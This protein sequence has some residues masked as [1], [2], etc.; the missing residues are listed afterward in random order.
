MQQ[1]SSLSRLQLCRW[2]SRFA[3]MNVLVFCLVGVAFIVHWPVPP[4]D[5]IPSFNLIAKAG[6]ILFLVLAFLGNSTL[7]AFLAAV[8]AFC[9]ALLFRQR[10]L[11]VLI[12]ILGASLMVLLLL[13]DSVVFHL[14]HYHMMGIVWQIYRSGA[15][16]QVLQFSWLEW[17]IVAVAGL[18]VFIL[19]YFVSRFVWYRWQKHQKQSAGGMSI[20]YLMVCL[21]FSYMALLMAGGVT[22][23]LSP[24]QAASTVITLEARVIPFY[25]F[26]F[27]ELMPKKSMADSLQTTLSGGFVELQNLVKPLNYPLHPLHFKSIKKP[28][29]IVVIGIDTWR[30]DQLN[31]TV[32]PNI[33]AFAQRS[34][35]FFDHYSGGNSTQP[36]LFSLFYSLPPNYWSAML[37]EK[38]G[39]VFIHQLLKDKYQ[40]G[41]FMSASMQFPAFDDT[42]F[43]EV[44][45]LQ[46]NTPG[47]DPYQRDKRITQEFTHFIKNRDG[48]RPFFSFLFYDQVHGYCSSGE[49]FPKPFQPAVDQCDHLTL[50]NNSDPVPYL[51]RYKNA[52]LFDDAQVGKVLAAIEQQHLLKN[53]VVIIT[54]D[55]GSEFNDTHQD[56]WGHAS[57]FTRYQTQVPMVIYWPG[58]KPKKIHHLTSHYDIVPLLMQRVLG[59]LNPIKDYSVGEPI[60]Q[61]GHRPYLIAAGYVN[62]AILTKKRI[63]II[64]PQGNY[65]MKTPAGKR[66][67]DGKF[68]LPIFK[69]V[70]ADENR[71]FKTS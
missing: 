7:L 31:K 39:P 42:I 65:V 8:P 57:G 54:S 30:F 21:Y 3:L 13:I 34:W 10:W 66:I 51:N 11:T 58:S 24:V 2:V 12:A 20:L 69:S 64:Y 29:N 62:H 50:T 40:M 19:E 6:A 25:E 44:K 5:S 37:Q 68:N 17:S 38:Q 45:P 56:L 22:Y 60:L 35:R 16:S 27:G 48:K 18:L 52:V 59:C 26:L 32:T 23:F 43:R 71:Y 61:A 53:T 36:G 9:V 46:I 14:Y 28:L 33:A 15:F 1:D 49:K 47:N 63:T 55:H 70:F 41:I 4:F 67:S